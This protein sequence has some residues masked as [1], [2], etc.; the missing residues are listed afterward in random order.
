MN[1]LQAL[2]PSLVISV[3]H[4]TQR[5]LSQNTLRYNYVAFASLLIR[6][7]IQFVLCPCPRTALQPSVRM[8]GKQVAHMRTCLQMRAATAR[9]VHVSDPNENL[10]G[11]TVFHSSLISSF[12]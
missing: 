1:M 9:K 2:P 10:N 12:L 6:N 4:W 5:E 8:C 3:R 11:W 7:S